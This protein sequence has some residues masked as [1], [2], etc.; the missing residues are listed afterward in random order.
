[1][2]Q[3]APLLRA[4]RHHASGVRQS[5][6]RLPTALPRTAVCGEPLFGRTLHQRLRPLTAESLRDRVI[7][8]ANFAGMPYA[9]I[10]DL[11]FGYSA[12]LFGMFLF[13]LG[14]SRMS[15]NR[16]VEL[17]PDGRLPTLSAGLSS[18]QIAE[19]VIGALIASAILAALKW[20]FG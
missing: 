18:H 2:W 11:L 15:R 20:F 1:M 16:R 19:E 13:I 12:L 17:T 6:A 14:V 7:I 5:G 4:A 10:E 9:T 8:P 3:P